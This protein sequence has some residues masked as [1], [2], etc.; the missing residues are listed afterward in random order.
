MHRDAAAFAGGVQSVDG[1]AARLV[2]DHVDA[3]HHVVVRRADGHGLFDHV[4]ALEVHGELAHLR[5][6]LEDLLGPEVAQVDEHV[7]LHALAEPAPLLDL[8]LDG[9]R[10]EVARPELHFVGR[11]ALHEALTFVVDED[12]ALAARSLGKQHARGGQPGGMELHELGILH[13]DA[14]A[15]TRRHA[16]AGH[17]RGVRGAR[18]VDAAE[19]ARGDDHRAGAER[20]DLAVSQVDGHDPLQLSVYGRDVEQVEL[21]EEMH[22]VLHAVLVQGV[23]HHVPCLVGRVAAP[24]ARRAAERALGDAALLVARVGH[25]HRLELQHKLRHP[26][27]E[28]LDGILVGQVIAALDRVE[29]VAFHGVLGVA[30]RER[31]VH[32]ALRGSGVGAGGEHLGQDGHAQRGVLAGVEGGRHAGTSR[33]H[34]DDVVRLHPVP[35]SAILYC[36][37][38]CS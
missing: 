6:A 22:A 30:V 15:Q 20:H 14:R 18:P 12:A 27:H 36:S 7:A 28:E 34:D 23:Q 19:P 3:A 25:A 37:T 2:I 31:R 38:P 32:A 35:Y 5:K 9:A 4:D 10:H 13:G 29:E 16:V 21:F 8:R 26:G 24:R 17:V 11:V 1:R 33:P